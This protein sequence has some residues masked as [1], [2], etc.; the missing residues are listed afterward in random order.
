MDLTH[1][2]TAGFCPDPRLRSLRCRH[3]HRQMETAMRGHIYEVRVAA[4][5]IRARR[6][7][8]FRMNPT[9]FL[10]GALLMLTVARGAAA[11]TEWPQFR[12]P[13]GQGLSAAKEV[14]VEWSNEKNV[15]WKVECV[16][17]G[18]SSPVVSQG[19]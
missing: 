7:P 10:A 17:R 18:W 1:L 6:G 11:E 12:G 3:S 19:R 4:A 8:L 13:N 9:T 15:A 16:G 14:P 2:H 5:K